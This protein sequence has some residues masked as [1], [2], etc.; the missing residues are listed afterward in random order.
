MK[1]FIQLNLWGVHLGGVDG[2]FV[3]SELLLPTSISDL[4]SVCYSGPRWLWYS[5]AAAGTV[6]CSV[7]GSSQHSLGAA[8]Q[9]A[10]FSREEVR[11]PVE[12]HGRY[13]VC[14]GTGR[15]HLCTQDEVVHGVWIKAAAGT[16]KALYEGERVCH[17]P[18]ARRQNFFVCLLSYSYG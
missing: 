14:K 9:V 1:L 8:A 6:G 2:R 12:S 5:I 18:S 7:L 17:L 16:A 10:V 15:P 13:L 4:N 11:A 3:C